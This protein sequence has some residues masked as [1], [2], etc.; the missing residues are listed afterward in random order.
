MTKRPAKSAAHKTARA[1][2][3]GKS[4]ATKNAPD[5][6]PDVGDQALAELKERARNV[7]SATLGSA[8]GLA[9]A[10]GAGML[11]LVAFVGVFASAVSDDSAAGVTVNVASHP[12]TLDTPTPTLT[13]GATVAP[14]V[15]GVML[16]GSVVGDGLRCAEDE[17]IAPTG[18][19]SAGCVHYER[20][21][22]DYLLECGIIGTPQPTTAGAASAGGT[23]TWC[24]SLIDDASDGTLSL[25]ELTGRVPRR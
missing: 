11:M 13:I 14:S 18:A 12:V 2:R 1:A 22:A 23:P 25:E 8:V 6:Q 4:A 17:L 16:G 7:W 9:L 19:D 21:I 3:V 20:V 5:A 10:L 15:Q 24:D